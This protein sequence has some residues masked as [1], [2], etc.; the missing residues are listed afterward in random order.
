M[1]L[2]RA[3]RA[4]DRGDYA[5][6][7]SEAVAAKPEA[8]PELEQEAALVARL[9]A[10]KLNNLTETRARL[11]FAENA[12]TDCKYCAYSS[13]VALGNML[14]DLKS[15]AAAAVKYRQAAAFA[16]TAEL[17]ERASTLA[18]TAENASRT[19]RPQG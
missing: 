11:E 6:A 12:K 13:K 10:M 3:S 19:L 2:A 7:Y 15:W 5:L 16:P 1:Q 14:V 18:E 9:S 4:Y 17:A 8:N